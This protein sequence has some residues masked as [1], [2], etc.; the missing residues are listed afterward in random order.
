MKKIFTL[1]AMA[2]MAFGASAQT[3][4]AEKD[5][6]G[7]TDDQLPWIQFAGEEGAY[8]GSAKGGADG[9]EITVTEDVGQLWQPQANVLEGF[10]LAVDGNYKVVIVAKLPCDG[11]LQINM[12]DWG[13]NFQYDFAVTATG[14]FQEIECEFP[15]YGGDATGAHVLFQCGNFVGTSIVKSVKVIHVGGGSGIKNVKT[16]KALNNVRYN[17]AGQKVD[18]SYK[19]IVIQNGKKFIQK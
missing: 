12:G 5:W 17:L 4:I 2:M 16:D 10:D 8:N 15:E 1:V 18:A 3:L 6:S 11:Q 7:V 13:T 9:I 19:G 14:D